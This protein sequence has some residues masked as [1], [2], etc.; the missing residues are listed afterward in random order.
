MRTVD[1]RNKF[2]Q[3]LVLGNFRLL[4]KVKGVFCSTEAMHK[5]LSSEENSTKGLSDINILSRIPRPLYCLFYG[6]NPGTRNF[7]FRTSPT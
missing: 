7:H 1:F 4:A 5:D 3:G 2:K 6:T